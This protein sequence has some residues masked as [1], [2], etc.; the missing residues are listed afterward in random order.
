VWGS[1][2]VMLSTARRLL[3]QLYRIPLLGYP[4]KCLV[5]NATLPRR[6]RALN[7]RLDKLEQVSRAVEEH[8]PTILNYITSFAH[9]SRELTRKYADFTATISDR[10]NTVEGGLER[11][12][13]TIREIQSRVEFIRLETLYEARYGSGPA[14]S[15]R[16][17]FEPKILNA[18]KL[19]AMSGSVRLNIGSGH[20]PMPEYM[21]ID[22]RELPGVDV[23]A[24][25]TNLPFSASSVVEVFSSHLMEHFP[26]TELVRVVLPYW[27]ELLKPRGTFRA[28]LPDW[29]SMIQQ[30]AKGD[31]PFEYL[32]E[33]TFG[34]QDYDGDFHYNM[35]S[36]DS[37]A[38]LLRA[39]G[40]REIAFP[41]VG[42][43][44]GKWLEIEVHAVKPS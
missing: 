12:A 7:E 8:L 26:Q 39:A 34:P 33:V 27:Y 1:A 10:L 13:S 16:Q 14:S 4:L 41:V 2:K 5:H 32:R 6:I 36:K 23:V 44:N 42:R 22:R 38:A 43:P 37:L 28:I 35:F 25:A 17:C 19:A 24:E 11:G 31:F 40:F 30:Y 21:N 29:E 9:T 18:E 20:V 15:W 3:V